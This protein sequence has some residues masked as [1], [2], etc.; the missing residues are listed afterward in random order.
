MASIFMPECNFMHG[1]FRCLLPIETVD[2]E[3]KVKMMRGIHTFR[4]DHTIQVISCKPWRPT[5]CAHPSILRK[6]QT[7]LE[8]E[9]KNGTQLCTST[10]DLTKPLHL[11]RPQFTKKAANKKKR[12]KTP[13][14]RQFKVRLIEKPSLVNAES[15]AV[16][17]T[18]TSMQI[19][20]VKQKPLLPIPA[21]YL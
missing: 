7:Y 6:M 8:L 5:P 1:Y 15:E 4:R 21:Q 13:L 12:T 19:P 16:A 3:V 10:N 18:V 17:T 2:V 20:V 9:G 11:R 14:M